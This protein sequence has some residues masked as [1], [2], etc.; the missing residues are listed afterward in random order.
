VAKVLRKFFRKKNKAITFIGVLVIIFSIYSLRVW[1]E[2]LEE[3]ETKIFPPSPTPYQ[4]PYQV[5]TLLKNQSY[6]IV[7][8]G[9]SIVEW[10]GLNANDLRLDLIKYYPDSEFVTYNYGYSA[11]NI[12]TLPDRLTTKTLNGKTENPSILDQDFDL[13]IIESFGYNPLSEYPLPEGLKKQEEVLEKSVRLILSRRPKAVL[14]F[15]TP[16]APDPINYAKG[17]YALSL[18]QRRA[19]VAERIAYIENHKQFAMNRGIPVIDIYTSSLLPDG[20][21]NRTYIA[22]DNIHP[23]QKGIKF[24]ANKIAEYIYNNKV[25]P[26]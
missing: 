16:I 19:W 7:V 23:S 24:I 8:V 25:F 17:I 4:F 22:E 3:L 15:M 6:R 5:P 13:I 26:E 9:D 2:P 21:V 10:L 11:T 18:E 14:L 12:L 1:K 20:S